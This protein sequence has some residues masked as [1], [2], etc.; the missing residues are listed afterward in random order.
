MSQF[1][2]LGHQPP[3][4]AF[5][6]KEDL[7][8]PEITYPL[9]LF[10]CSACMLV[11]LGYA[12]DP[13]ILFRDYVYNTGSNNS[14][15]ANFK[16]LVDTIISEY[17]LE[18]GGFVIDIGSN[19]G[20]LLEN[21][22]PHNIKVLGIDPS[23]ATS[24]ALEKG[25]PTLVDYFTAETAVKVR[26]EK[27]EAKIITATNVFAH[28]KE[29]DSFMRGVKEILDEKGVFISENGYVVDM[30]KGMQYD[31]IYHEHLRYY[32]VTALCV[33]F[34]RYDMEVINV[35]RI[36]SHGGSIRVYAVHKGALPVSKNVAALCA[37]EKEHG[38][39]SLARYQT[40]ANE[41]VATK[42]ALLDIIYTFKKKG[43]RIFGIGAPAKGN[44]LLNYCKLDTTIVDCLTEKSALKIGLYS[45]G[46][47]IPVVDDKYLFDEQPEAA[48]LLSWNLADELVPKIR[49]K[50]YKGVFI[51]PNPVPRSIK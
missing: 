27:G 39:T 10:F 4:D 11:Q 28:V 13:D 51:I 44:T 42:L 2:S 47:H 14:L 21:Y 8:K 7:G 41:V 22:L 38:F 35:E 32:S 3:S 30:I 48:L 45:P 40:F 17:R 19:D 24:L 49:Q 43:A 23:S 29:L 1:L 50:G 20:T 37:L 25:I 12:V 33:L 36:P 9:D 34:E 31:A 46:M 6:K 18:A 16:A 5:L 26:K 15:K